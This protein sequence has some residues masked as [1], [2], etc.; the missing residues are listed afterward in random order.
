MRL[1][2][3]IFAACV[4]LV[5][6]ACGKKDTT[7]TPK[8]T[9]D[10]T[11][12]TPAEVQSQVAQMVKPRPGMYRTTMRV[13]KFEIPGMPAAQSERMK[14]MFSNAGTAR[15]FCVTEEMSERGYR[16]YSKNLAQGN[17]TVDSF[18]A[19]GGTINSAMTCQTG[20]GATSKVAMNG[21]VTPDG[22]TVHMKMEQQM[23][24]GMPV[25]LGAVN[26]EMEVVSERTGD[27]AG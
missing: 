21:T 22:S 18:A 15:E 26:M 27:C 12:T 8:G 16:D 2:T 24:P 11:A 13:I 7:E 19:S 3:L 5:L 4:P 10:A 6:T 17:C 9:A 1:S 20:R 25:K 14:G 23:P